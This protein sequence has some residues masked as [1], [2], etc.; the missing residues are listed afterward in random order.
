MCLVPY[1]SRAC[2][3]C[4]S[5]HAQDWCQKTPG[6]GVVNDAQTGAYAR[7]LHDACGTYDSFRA[8]ISA[9][10]DYRK[11]FIAVE[12]KCADSTKPSALQAVKDLLK[13][14][15]QLHQKR[16]AGG[17]LAARDA[18]LITMAHVAIALTLCLDQPK[19]GMVLRAELLLQV[20]LARRNSDCH[21]PLY[22]HLALR[23]YARLEAPELESSGE[24]LQFLRV[25]FLQDATMKVNR[26]GPAHMAVHPALSSHGS[27]ALASTHSRR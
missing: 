25:L 27:K 23:C 4:T 11:H 12:N 13:S 7:H 17:D 15:D 14:K 5:H 1:Q 8:K 6:A 9:L 3:S 19:W 22:K 21:Q 24:V 20:A 16:L 10:N 2:L 26:G 18:R